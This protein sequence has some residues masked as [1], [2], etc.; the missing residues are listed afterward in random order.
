MDAG[1]GAARAGP[2]A[3]GSPVLRRDLLAL[4]QAPHDVE[5]PDERPHPALPERERLVL[6]APVAQPDAEHEAAAGEDVQRRRLFGDLDRVEQ[7]E[8]EDPR[9]DPHPSASAAR[10]ASSGT[11][12]SISNG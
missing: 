2:R 6:L 4:E 12:W 9:A 7:G 5:L 8:Q 10:R 1:P 11:G 3:S